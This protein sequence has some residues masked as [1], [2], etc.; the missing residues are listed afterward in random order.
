MLCGAEKARPMNTIVM[1]TDL[2]CAHCDLHYQDATPALFSFNSAV[3][4][5]D[6]CRGFGRVIGIDYGL[7]IPDETKSLAGG[8]VKP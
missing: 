6:T 5:C 8:A 3:G 2:H 7:V 1:P 4:A